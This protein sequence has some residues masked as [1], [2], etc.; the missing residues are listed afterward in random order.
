MITGSQEQQV[1]NPAVGELR[2]QKLSSA[3]LVT[4]L[5]LD[6]VEGSTQLCVL[7]VFRLL[8]ACG[9]GSPRCHR[10]CDQFLGRFFAF[11]H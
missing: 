8:L 10:M 2:R 3:R 5:N 11:E 6:T 9:S 7:R 4:M 1:L